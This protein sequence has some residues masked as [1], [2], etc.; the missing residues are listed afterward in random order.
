MNLDSEEVLS[1]VPLSAE[2]TDVYFFHRRERVT[3][4]ILISVKRYIV[5]R[6]CPYRRVDDQDPLGIDLEGSQELAQC[7]ADLK[8]NV[9]LRL[10]RPG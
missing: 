7:A 5:K 8:T 9:K 1:A 4:D 10:L 6:S 2:R 3:Q